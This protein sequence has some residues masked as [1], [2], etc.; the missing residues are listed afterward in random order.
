MRSLQLNCAVVSAELYG[1]FSSTTKWLNL[2]WEKVFQKFMDV[3]LAMVRR[4]Q[5]RNARLSFFLYNSL[6]DIYNGNTSKGGNNPE[7][8]LA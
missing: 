5:I 7:K 1:S 6:G 4:C 2:T 8:G 3:F